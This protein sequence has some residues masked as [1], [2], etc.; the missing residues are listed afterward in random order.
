MHRNKAWRIHQEKRIIKKEFHILKDIWHEDK[1]IRKGIERKYSPIIMDDLWMR[2][3]H[4]ANNRKPCS[5][6]SCCNPRRDDW[7]SKKEKLTIQERRAF[8][9]AI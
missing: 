7:L 6:Y 4:M 2:A 5:C 8:Q 9:D 3:K 1:F